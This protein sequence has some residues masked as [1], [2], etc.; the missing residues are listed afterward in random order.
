MQMT[1]PLTARSPRAFTPPTLARKHDEECEAWAKSK[2]KSRG[3]KPE[4][5]VFML[6][7]PTLS[8]K[9]TIGQL[10]FELGVYPTSRDSVRNATLEALLE[11]GGEKA[12]DDAAWLEGHW[13]KTEIYEQQLELWQEQENQR[14]LDQ[15]QNPKTARE[16]FPMPEPMTDVRDRI[17]A[18]KMVDGIIARDATVRRMLAAQTRYGRV[19]EIMSV[20]VHLRGWQGLETQREAV[21]E[22]HL[23]D[24]VTEESI[25]ALR[26]EIGRDAWRELWAEID[27]MYALTKAEVGNSDSPGESEPTKDGSKPG[28]RKTGSGT[29]N[30]T[31]KARKSSSQPTPEPESDQTTEAS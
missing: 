30:G 16:A 1:I 23:P 24:I 29:S 25:D 8:E 9:E 4:K 3:P 31:R 6:A 20:R 7:V 12:E 19:Y 14:L 21:S 28:K 26:E 13:Q 10:M 2:S 27:S 22:L 5:P 11:H 15:W 17:K 18:H